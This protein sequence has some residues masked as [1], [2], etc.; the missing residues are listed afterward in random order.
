[1]STPALQT[2]AARLYDWCWSTSGAA[3]CVS[4]TSS[5][6]P[7]C[8]YDTVD[9]KRNSNKTKQDHQALL[10]AKYSPR[11]AAALCTQK[12]TKKNSCD[13]DLWPM[14]SQFN[15]VLETSG[16][17]VI[18]HNF[19][20]VQ[21]NLVYFGLLTKNDL[22]LWPRNSIGFYRLSRY[23]FIQNFIKLSY[24]GHKLFCPISEW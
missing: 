9:N 1:M 4:P 21:N 22:D 12:N 10:K 8:T 6:Q 16:N 7:I 19:F 24:R 23:I 17:G 11:V 15:R 14:T 20:H 13:L 5:T 18:N 2:S 3:K